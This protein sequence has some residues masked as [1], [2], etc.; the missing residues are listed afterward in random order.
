MTKREA[1]MLAKNWRLGNRH[2]KK[3]LTKKYDLKTATSGNTGRVKM[4]IRIDIENNPKD[5]KAALDDEGNLVFF[6]GKPMKRV[7]VS[8][9]FTPP[10]ARK[11][12]MEINHKLEILKKV[13]PKEDTS[14]LESFLSYFKF[15]LQEYSLVDIQ[16]HFNK[17]LS[18]RTEYQ[19]VAL[20]K[21]G[22]ELKSQFYKDEN[23]L[24]DMQHKCEELDEYESTTVVKRIVDTDEDIDD[25]D[26]GI[27]GT[28]DISKED[29]EAVDSIKD[30]PLV[31]P[32]DK[33]TLYKLTTLAL[34][35]IPH[36]PKQKETIKKLNILRKKNGMKPLKASTIPADMEIKEAVTLTF[37]GKTDEVIDQLTPELDK[38]K[39]EIIDLDKGKIVVD[40][41]NADKAIKG[42]MKKF[43]KLKLKTEDAVSRAQEL[44]DLKRKHE[45]EI[46]AEK[47]E[48][49]NIKTQ[50][51]ELSPKQKKLDI[52]GDGD[53]GADDLAKLRKGKKKQE[54][55]Y[56]VDGRKRAFREKLR[57]LGYIKSATH[58]KKKTVPY[59]V[60]GEMYDPD[61]HHTK[62]PKSHVKLNKETGMYCVYDM[63]G[64]KRAEFDNKKD[65]EAYSIKHHDKLMNKEAVSRAQQAAIAI[66]KKKSGKYDKDGKR[67]A[68]A[69][70]ITK[71][72]RDELEDNNQHAELALRLAQSFG[73]PAE[74]KKIKSI[75]KKH[76]QRGSIMP[77][78]L[79]VRNAISN[80]Y[81]KMAVK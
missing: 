73:T 7:Q 62:D 54:E 59:E 78:E 26:D 6:T 30:R 66:S 2:R 45:R 80:K 74:V 31:D 70:K 12:D 72:E 28:A 48:I 4:G 14:I 63:K 41:K 71:K 43:K 68:E 1:E 79:K 46:E 11:E 65:A 53:I 22:T 64:K 61:K 77:N 9:L 50:D 34:K 3:S 32:R 24:S 37:K 55:E 42:L 56:K 5:Y 17:F 13:Y 21:D 69:K 27:D 60:Y 58:N 76:M 25:E 47:D 19:L 52:D 40:G 38:A 39:L 36:S 67:L 23:E 18:E 35:Q 15:E 16:Q 75:N 44:A 8:D 49:E 57:R 51:E 20:K 33:E 29:N 81:Y 10:K